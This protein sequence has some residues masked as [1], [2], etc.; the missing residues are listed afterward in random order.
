MAFMGTLQKRTFMDDLSSGMQTG[1]PLA[2]MLQGKR[3]Q[4]EEKEKQKLMI[5]MAAY[6]AGSEE[7]RRQMESSPEWPEFLAAMAK[8]GLSTMVP[9][10]KP[11][12]PATPPPEP[13]FFGK[14]SEVGGVHR[15][16][17][18]EVEQII[19]GPQVTPK[20]VIAKPGE[21][22][23]HYNSTQGKFIPDYQVPATKKPLTLSPGQVVLDQDAQGNWIEQYQAPFKPTEEKPHILKAGESLIDS[24]GKVLVK[25]PGELIKLEPGQSIVDAQGNVIA[26]GL[27][28]EYQ[29]GMLTVA[30]GELVRKTNTDEAANR[31]TMLNQRRADA[32]LK[33][34]AQ[35]RKAQTAEGVAR[36]Q[37]MNGVLEFEKEKFNA[38]HEYNVTQDEFLNQLKSRVADRAD[39]KLALE[40]SV[41]R[42][43]KSRDNVKLALEQLKEEHQDLLGWA[44]VVEAREKNRLLEQANTIKQFIADYQ[45]EIGFISAKLKQAEFDLKEWEK[46]QTVPAEVGL[47][48][49]QTKAAIEKMK[50]PEYMKLGEAGMWKSIYGQRETPTLVPGTVPPEDPQKQKNILSE[51]AGKA[52]AATKPAGM[53]EW[54]EELLNRYAATL[55]AYIE[56]D[57]RLSDEIKALY[58]SY[59]SQ[60]TGSALAIGLEG[61][62]GIVP[63]P[64]S[65]S[66]D[67]FEQIYRGATEGRI[68]PTAGGTSQIDAVAKEAMRIYEEEGIEASEKYAQSQGF[69]LDQIASYLKKTRKK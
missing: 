35:F 69:T 55:R 27:I 68:T 26:T 6:Q 30:E 49:A 50:R 40:T 21:V 60:I 20:A 1:V 14:P 10:G 7:T 34:L 12:M 3:Q 11:V 2:Q 28:S 31:V 46:K 41:A 57:P 29:K 59:I 42:W 43:D 5:I 56:V 33:S 62:G 47:L 8:S 48:G 38:V 64:G 61:E 13:E 9:G 36:I 37:N 54:G 66:L 45:K 22:V 63:L 51:L 15:V 39:A 58:K 18:E 24:S 52:S 23:G 53:L 65:I 4:E 32:A 16:I 17:G 19:P 25:M 44:K 67:E